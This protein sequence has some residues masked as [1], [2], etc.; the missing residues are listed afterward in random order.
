[1]E[2]SGYLGF[3]LFITVDNL[4]RLGSFNLWTCRDE[5][6]NVMWKSNLFH[7]KMFSTFAG[8]TFCLSVLVGRQTLDGGPAVIR[9]IDQED[10]C[11]Q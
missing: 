5:N 2:E 4:W 8:L 11:N 7:G 9:D 10:G 6:E 3:L 1:M